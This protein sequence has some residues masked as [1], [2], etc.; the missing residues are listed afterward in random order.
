M[1]MYVVVKCIDINTIG[2]N[3][4]PQLWDYSVLLALFVGLVLIKF[5]DLTMHICRD[6]Y[7]ILVD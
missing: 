5:N 1:L 6:I 2:F 4:F 7:H 3:A